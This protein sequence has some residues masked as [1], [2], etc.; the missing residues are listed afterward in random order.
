[1]TAHSA[2]TLSARLRRKIARRLQLA[3]WSKWLVVPTIA[4]IV[5]LGRRS[6]WLGWGFS[7]LFMLE[8]LALL[9]GEA[10]RCPLCDT[11]LV[12]IRDRQEEFEHACPGCGFILD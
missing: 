10:Q 11:P 2:S 5:Y 7:A 9:V 6:E 8:V 3:R 12:T 1:M 4:A